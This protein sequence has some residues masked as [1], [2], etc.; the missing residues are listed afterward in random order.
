MF[1]SKNLLKINFAFDFIANFI[2]KWGKFNILQSGVSGITKYG[3][4]YKLGQ[5]L[6][7]KAAYCTW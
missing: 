2:T 5:L 1:S 6:E 4:Y 3:K 7:I